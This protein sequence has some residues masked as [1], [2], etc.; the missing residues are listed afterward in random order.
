MITTKESFRDYKAEAEAWITLVTGEYY[1]DILSDAC[2]LYE[3]VLLEFERL[4]EAAHSSTFFSTSI[5]ET[6]NQSMR[7]QLCRI[8]KKYVSPQ[9]PVEILKRK[10]DVAK[11]CTQFGNAFRNIVEVQQKFESRSMPDEVLCAVL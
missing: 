8:F 10:R 4:L 2:R 7:T 5:I 9:I 11:I 3:P 1:P 6:Q